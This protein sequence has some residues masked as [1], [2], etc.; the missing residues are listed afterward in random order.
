MEHSC[1]VLFKQKLQGEISY[2]LNLWLQWSL[3]QKG[4]ASWASHMQTVSKYGILLLSRSLLL[5]A[6]KWKDHPVIPHHLPAA[7]HY[8]A[9][10]S[11]CPAEWLF[12]LLV[13]SVP[14]L[15]VGNDLVFPRLENL[16]LNIGNLEWI[17]WKPL[18]GCMNP[19]EKRAVWEEKKKD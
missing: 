8:L 19:L 17:L 16:M 2:T 14:K 12:S 6:V 18:R 11:Y 1:S 3:D 10:K 5:M 15:Q 7:H 9:H 4:S 13:Q